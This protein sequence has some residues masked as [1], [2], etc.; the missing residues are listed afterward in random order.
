LASGELT[1]DLVIRL[2]VNPDN[3]QKSEPDVLKVCREKL[4]VLI[5]S[6][7]GNSGAATRIQIRG[8]N[9]FLETASH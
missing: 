9:S 3:L 5:S 1:A 4:P 2:Q 6:F 8:N 7:A